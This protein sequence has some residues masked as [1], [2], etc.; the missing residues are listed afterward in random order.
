MRR[1]VAA[2]DHPDRTRRHLAAGAYGNVRWRGALDL[3]LAAAVAAQ[4]GSP[5]P[6]P[7]G[8][9]A[10]AVVCRIARA[11]R[12]AGCSPIAAVTL[13]AAA[14][15]DLSFVHGGP[16]KEV[17]LPLVDEP[18]GD[19]VAQL[20]AEDPEIDRL[21][22]SP[23]RTFSPTFSQS[24][25]KRRRARGWFFWAISSPTFSVECEKQV[26][27]AELVAL[28]TM[29]LWINT[30]KQS[31]LKTIEGVDVVIINDAEARQLTEIPNLIK[32]ARLFF[33]GDR[34]H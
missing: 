31:L 20:Q 24:F 30:A 29:N 23:H 5:W 10:T 4:G 15:P 9:G 25:P 22:G 19:I 17:W 3:G 16:E 6:I 1:H 27:N 21:V 8:R 2:R 28:D 32:A 13:R 11:R 12:L 34:G 18:V 7:L 33:R 26:P 14:N